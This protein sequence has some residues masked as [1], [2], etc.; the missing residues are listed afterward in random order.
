MSTEFV[1]LLSIFS[2]IVIGVFLGDK[3]PIAT[4][5]QSAPRLASKIERDIS[6]GYQFSRQGQE[7]RIPGWIK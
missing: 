5:R 4:F 7:E 1:L 6:I 3:G 2:F